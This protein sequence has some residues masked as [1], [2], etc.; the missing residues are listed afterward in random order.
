MSGRPIAYKELLALAELATGYNI[1]VPGVEGE[2][3]KVRPD[4]EAGRWVVVRGHLFG[5]EYLTLAGWQTA[6]TDPAW[7]FTWSLPQALQRA[8]AAAAQQGVEH[9]QWLAARTVRADAPVE[10][11]LPQAVSA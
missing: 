4:V 1:P 2:V 3:V 5:R 7:R 6:E 9:A 11:L 10:L 8:Q